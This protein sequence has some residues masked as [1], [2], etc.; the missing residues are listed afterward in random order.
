MNYRHFVALG[1]I[2]SIGL[3]PT[4]GN[5]APF[6]F[7]DKWTARMTTPVTEQEQ[8]ELNFLACLEDVTRSIPDR[9]NVQ[10]QGNSDSYLVQRTQDLSYPRLR[11]VGYPSFLLDGENPEYAIFIGPGEP[12]KGDLLKQSDCGG[13]VFSAVKL[14]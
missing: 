4:A 8:G 7:L 10:I 13:I 1:L 6:A 14:D 5:F 11:L 2:L 9:T 12:P 3:A